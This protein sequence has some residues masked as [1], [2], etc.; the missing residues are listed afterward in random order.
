MN[1]Y[2]RYGALGAAG[3]RHLVEFM[4]PN[5]YLG[6]PKMVKSWKYNLTTVDFR[7]QQMKERIEESQA[8]AEGKKILDIKPSG[9]EATDLMKAILGHQTIISN[10]N[11]P[12][13]GQ[14]PQLPIGA[15]VETNCIFENDQVKPIVSKPLPLSVLHMVERA[16]NNIDTLYEGIKERNLDKIFACF[17]NQALCSSLSL[18]EGRKLFK[19]MIS[20][21]KLYLKN[22]Y[23]NLEEYIK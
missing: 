21:T 23:S 19:E 3:D 11:M 5:W 10:V 1:L 17:M 8:L 13:Q 14:C 18:E 20:N 4:N 12:N 15:I 9:E 22:Y 6:N 2:Q 7:I 16:C